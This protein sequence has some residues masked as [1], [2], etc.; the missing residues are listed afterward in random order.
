MN[1][2]TTRAC[3]AWTLA[4]AGSLAAQDRD[5][6]PPRPVGVRPGPAPGSF[7]GARPPGMPGGG[8]HGGSSNIGGAPAM[9]GGGIVGGPGMPG[10]PGGFRG[11][12]KSWHCPRCQREVGQGALPPASVNCCGQTFVNGDNL[13]GG[14]D[15][16]P[17]GADPALPPTQPP[18]GAFPTNTVAPPVAASGDDPAPAGNGKLVALGVGIIVVGLMVFGAIVFLALKARRANPRPRRRRRVRDYE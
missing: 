14:A 3:L 11:T 2:T 10:G 6:V 5:A 13:H 9:S 17:P 4:L 12:E 1:P 15:R 18:D 16:P 8:T 7:T